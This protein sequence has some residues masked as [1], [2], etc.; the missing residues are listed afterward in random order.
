MATAMSQAIL[1]QRIDGIWHTGIVVYSCEYY[2]G[3][4]IQVSAAGQFAASNQLQPVQMLEMGTT[5]K[6]QQELQAYL[7]TINNLFTQA[8]YDLINN[9]CNNFADNVCNFLTGHGIPS[10][11]VD[12]PRIVFSTPGGAMLRPMI[13]GMQNN[14]RQQ[15]GSGMDPFGGSSSRPIS[16]PVVAPTPTPALASAAGNTLGRGAYGGPQVHQQRSFESSLSDS[17]RAVGQNM[18]RMHTQSANTNASSTPATAAAAAGPPAKALLEES[19]LISGDASTV[20]A[21]GRKMLNLPGADGVAGSALGEAEKSVLTSVL[22]ELSTPSATT[23]INNN[24]GVR[25]FSIEAYAL[26]ERILAEHTAAHMACL[27]TLRLMLLHDRASDLDKLGIIREIIRRLT[28]SAGGG[29]VANGAAKGKIS[30]FASIPAHVLAL[31][32]ISNLLSHETGA[33]ASAPHAGEIVDAALSGLSHSRAEIRQMSATLAYN[34]TLL[35]TKDSKLTGAW[36]NTDQTEAVE[37]N[38]HA[39]QLLCGSLEGLLQEGDATV[40]RRRL[41]VVCRILRAYGALAVELVADLGLQDQLVV[42][43]TD[44]DITPKLSKEERDILAEINHMFA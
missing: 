16:T 32:A 37:I 1:G 22:A 23:N 43:F 18:E 24:A 7:R 3:G 4:G 8:T 35:H 44:K 31:C 38:P 25:K 40:R 17:V 11:I 41:A 39:L 33:N 2:F 6:T 26:M 10:H 34:Y 14:M 13:E 29:G 15:Q 20:Q 12:L 27:F 5:T 28:L 30:A 36:S 21:I 19:A 9:N 42:L